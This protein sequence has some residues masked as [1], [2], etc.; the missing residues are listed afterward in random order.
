MA[1]PVFNRDQ[2]VTQAVAG[3]RP[4]SGHYEEPLPLPVM[5]FGPVQESP[6]APDTR[7]DLFDHLK[8]TARRLGGQHYEEPLLLPVMN[9]GPDDGPRAARVLGAAQPQRNAAGGQQGGETPLLLPTM[10]F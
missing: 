5:N 7:S 1:Q 9:F 2:F 4:V 3:H 10:Q 6:P 8:A